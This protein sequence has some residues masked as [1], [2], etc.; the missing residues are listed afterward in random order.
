MPHPQDRFGDAFVDYLIAAEMVSRGTGPA[1]FLDD[2]QFNN[3]IIFDISLLDEADL[4][5]LWGDPAIVRAREL[6]VTPEGQRDGDFEQLYTAARRRAWRKTPRLYTT[7]YQ[8]AMEIEDPLAKAVRVSDHQLYPEGCQHA[9][10]PP[11]RGS[12][13]PRRLCWTQGHRPRARGRPR[14]Q[15]VIHPGNMSTKALP[16]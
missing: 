13:R 5:D 14:L 9:N 1:R 3:P 7:A 8:A 10:Q 6:A 16:R 11:S 2:E 15:G 12:S 4:P